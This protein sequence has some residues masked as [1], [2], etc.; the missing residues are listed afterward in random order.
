MIQTL[1]TWSPD[2]GDRIDY[3]IRT[4][5]FASL[6]DFLASMPTRPYSE[7]ARLLGQIAP[8]QIV[9]VQFQ[10]AKSAGRVRAAAKDS[11]CRNLLEQLPDGWGVGKN[12]EW[13]AVRALSSWSSDIQVTGKCEELE[14]KLLGIAKAL[15]DMPPPQGWIPNGPEDPVIESIFN[16]RWP[17]D[18]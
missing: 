7:V 16:L 12:A 17:L 3:A 10:E 5:G 11:L 9:A 18:S 6:T 2:W 4:L 15:H 14:Q 1:S 8:I 13:Q